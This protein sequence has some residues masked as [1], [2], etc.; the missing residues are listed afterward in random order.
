L[1]EFVR[2]VDRPDG[3]KAHTTRWGGSPACLWPGYEEE[4]VAKWH[5]FFEVK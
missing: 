1:Q 2:H 4:R 3:E 5:E